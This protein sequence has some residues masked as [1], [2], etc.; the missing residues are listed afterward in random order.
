MNVT[1]PGQSGRLATGA[2]DSA[3]SRRVTISASTP[4]G[5][6]TKKIHRHDSQLVKAPPSTGPI[7]TA[8]PVIAPNTPNATPRS[9]GGKAS[10]S[11]A[12][13]VANMIAPPMPWKRAGQREEGRV[14][15]DA[16]ERGPDR[17]H[18]DADREHQPSPDEV[19]D[20]SGR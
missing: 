3:T 13:E 6:F 20:R 17:E 18:D 9:R 12:S 14:G 8:T 19:R 11:S 5:T 15:G 1:K 2:F 16:A 10:A 4:I 7:A